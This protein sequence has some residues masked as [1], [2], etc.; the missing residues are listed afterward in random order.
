MPS[1]VSCAGYIPDSL[2]SLDL[3]DLVNGKF[4]LSVYACSEKVVLLTEESKQPNTHSW[5]IVTQCCIPESLAH[6][7]QGVCIH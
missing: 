3:V 5:L 1:Y 2:F 4:S 7:Q 6:K